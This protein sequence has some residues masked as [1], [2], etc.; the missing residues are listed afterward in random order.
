MMDDRM[1]KGM[2]RKRGGK[3]RQ[4]LEAAALLA[5][6]LIA[7]G[8]CGAEEGTP[9]D[10]VIQPEKSVVRVKAGDTTGSAVLRGVSID[11]ERTILLTAGHVLENLSTEELPTVIF[12][13]GTERLCDGYVSSDSIDVAVLYISDAKLAKKLQQDG[14]FTLED[15][16]RFDNLRDGD[17]C[18]AIGGGNSEERAVCTGEI[19]DNWI[20][21]ED[22]AQY[23]IWAEVK[24]HSGMS[25]GGLFDSE[26]Y[27]LGILSGG[28]ED[29]QLA[30][31]PL[32][33]ILSEFHNSLD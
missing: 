31:V 12:E 29:G 7:L 2:K 33:L 1:G 21:M 27:F 9:G 30:A 32:S 16:G 22:Y 3:Q 5:A 8:G 23:M 25:G 6:V 10:T 26:G 17:N 11:G 15:M 4:Y 19:L 20:Y 13:D 24:I 18:I 28:S 14:C